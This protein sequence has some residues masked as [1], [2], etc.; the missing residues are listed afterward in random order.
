MFWI[1]KA[2]QR[3]RTCTCYRTIPTIV[4]YKVLFK[5]NEYYI[6]YFFNLVKEVEL[7]KKLNIDKTLQKLT[8]AFGEMVS[9]FREDRSLS[10]EA[11]S[12]LT[13]ISRSVV[14]RIETDNED[15][16][17][18][19]LSSILKFIN[20]LEKPIEDVFIEMVE[21]ANLS[22]N[23]KD[24]NRIST[25]IPD[26]ILENI[27][28][29]KSKNIKDNIKWAFNIADQVSKLSE[30]KKIEFEMELL[31]NKKEKTTADKRRLKQL[32]SIILDL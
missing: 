10:R 32:M 7:K 25:L 27:Q 14:I 1:S 31:K 5:T 12:E 17:N 28:K 8:N 11:F 19:T 21:K 9:E 2:N 22:K 13:N 15:S 23:K 3:P 26:S 6:K 4:L 16:K 29:Q 30:E 18:L 24:V 20:A